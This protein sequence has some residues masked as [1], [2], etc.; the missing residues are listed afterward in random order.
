MWSAD[1][2]RGRQFVQFVGLCYMS[3]FRRMVDGIMEGL[4]EP[5]D[6]ATRDRLKLE[7]SL[8]GWIKARSTQDIFDWFD[9]VETTEVQTE[10]GKFRWSTESIRRD[11]LFLE[12]LGVPRRE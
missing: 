11:E 4:G 5:R 8:K 3:R 6:G 12:L 10:A 7:K 2:L 9:C 1:A